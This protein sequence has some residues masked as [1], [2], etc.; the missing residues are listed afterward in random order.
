MR[1]DTPTLSFD[2]NEQILFVGFAGLRMNTDAQIRGAFGAIER[3]WV[4]ECASQKVYAVVDYTD[5]ALDIALT[6]AYAECVKHAVE[7][8]AITAVRYT[9][10]LSTRANLR[11]VAVK[12]H[13]RS[14]L[15][16]TR[17]DAIAVVR[18]LRAQQIA[19]LDDASTRT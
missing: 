1:R 19:L 16:A 2:G 4:S 3:F 6:D 15:Y 7:T 18:G 17:E 10:D 11:A 14:N 12:A 13:L 5:F 8:F 9:T